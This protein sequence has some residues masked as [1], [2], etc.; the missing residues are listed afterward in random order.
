MRRGGSQKT[1]GGMCKAALA[2]AKHSIVCEA[3]FWQGRKGT[4][5]AHDDFFERL[6]GSSGE[7]GLQLPRTDHDLT[8][9]RFTSREHES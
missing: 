2:N 7:L 5:V 6:G 1:H 4:D 9:E 3:V 8:C